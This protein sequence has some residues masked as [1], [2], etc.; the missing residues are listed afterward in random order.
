MLT[1]VAGE[2]VLPKIM[3]TMIDS[4]IGNQAAGL[5]IN[6]IVSQALLMIGCILIMITGGDFVFFKHRA[7]IC[8][9]VA[10]VIAVCSGV[11]CGYK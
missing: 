6:Y 9:H 5:G 4:G 7:E 10:E 11:V 3:G 2:I 8:S 1:E